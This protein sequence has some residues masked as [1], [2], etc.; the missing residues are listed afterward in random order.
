VKKKVLRLQTE[1]PLACLWK[2]FQSAGDP[3]MPNSRRLPGAVMVRSLLIAALA[4]LEQGKGGQ[5]H[6]ERPAINATRGSNHE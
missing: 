4:R 6:F 5:G 2:S 1:V 3:V